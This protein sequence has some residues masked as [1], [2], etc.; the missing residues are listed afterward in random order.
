MKIFLPGVPAACRH[1][2][3]HKGASACRAAGV[4]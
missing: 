4:G 3:P 1:A 2:S